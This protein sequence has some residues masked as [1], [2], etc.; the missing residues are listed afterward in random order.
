MKLVALLPMKG[1]SERVPNK[2]IRDFCGKPLYHWILESLLASDYIDHVVIN[3][4]S[5][6]IANDAIANFDRVRV[7]DRPASIQGDHTPMNDIIAY[8]LSNTEAEHYIQTHSTN[9]LLRTDTMNRAVE[10][11]LSRLDEYD[12]LFSVTRLQTRLYSKDGLPMNHDPKILLRTQDLEP[13]FEEN[14]NIYVFSKASFTKSKNRIG[15]KPQIM[16]IEKL[17]SVDIDEESDFKIAEML[18]RL[19]NMESIA[20]PQ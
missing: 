5:Q 6:R 20:R 16:E 10:R 2:N 14:S 8:D 1:H 9:P 3:T 4:D 15:E 12:S 11:Y 18:C 19:G 7:I 17:E 13:L